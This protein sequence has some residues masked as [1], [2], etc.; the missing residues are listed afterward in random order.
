MCVGVYVCVCVC[1]VGAHRVLGERY[2]KY[3]E[4]V[5]GRQT[6]ALYRLNALSPMRSVCLLG[7]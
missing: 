5:L 3:N 4:P 1:C 2:T 6:L 7:T